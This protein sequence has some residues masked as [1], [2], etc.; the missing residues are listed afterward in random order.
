M[1]NR[2]IYQLNTRTLD[3]T[4]VIPV[5]DASGSDEMGKTT[6]QDLQNL[7]VK[8]EVMDDTVLQGTD[9]GTTAVLIYGINVVT[10]STTGDFCA[11]LPLTPVKGK[12]VT[13][14]NTSGYKAR[15]FPSVD[16]GKINGVVDGYF[17]VPN[18]SLPYDF[19]CY[20]NPNPGYWGTSQRPSNAFTTI[21][22]PEITVTH[23]GTGQTSFW[24]FDQN[25]SY[26]NGFGGYY[27]GNLVLT[28]PNI[29]TTLNVP[30]TCVGVRAYSNIVVGDFDQNS[31]DHINITMGIVFVADFGGGA[32]AYLNGGNEGNFTKYGANYNTTIV[33]AANTLNSP[34]LIGDAGTMIN[35]LDLLGTVYSQQLGVNNLNLSRSYYTFGMTIPQTLAAKDYK[36]RFEIDYI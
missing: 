4:D 10:A 8:Q 3:L 17:D 24:G 31:N 23:A 15:I 28:S 30:A 35:T 13:V 26:Q 32:S 33:G 25:G 14:I 36:F 21:S 1:A 2:Q 29:Y 27:N 20:E 18:D 19:V 16:G 5:Q 7:L 12:K 22:T 6:L 9:T 11:R 34:P